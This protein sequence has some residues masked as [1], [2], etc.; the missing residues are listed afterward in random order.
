MEAFLILI[1]F[2]LSFALF[3][4]I[5]K[6]NRCRQEISFLKQELNKQK[7]LLDGFNRSLDVD[8]KK[9]DS[10]VLEEPVEEIKQEESFDHDL[11]EKLRKKR[12]DLAYAR[13]VSAYMIFHDKTL[14]EMASLKPA[15]REDFSRLYGVGE[16][17]L[18]EFS[19]IF[20]RVINGLPEETEPEKHEDITEKVVEEEHKYVES[21]QSGGFRID[22]NRSI[23]SNEEIDVLTKKGDWIFALINKR[24]VPQNEEDKRLLAVHND[25]I[26]PETFLEKVWY[27]Y[28][29]RI[30]F[31][32]ENPSLPPYD[33]I[34]PAIEHWRI[35]GGDHMS[36]YGRKKVFFNKKR[37]R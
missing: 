25:E 8:E 15:T 35:E 27:K 37:K 1:V 36:P 34:G 12:A 3:F 29:E 18:N 11:F 22:C 2:A 33:M 32:N 30:K 26:E 10:S 7:I 19:D 5:K 9:E 16:F 31:E 4:I 23:F 6:L 17:K 13:K 20:L 28:K 24:I 21:L 14:K